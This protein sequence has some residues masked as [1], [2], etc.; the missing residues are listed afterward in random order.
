MQLTELSLEAVLFQGEQQGDFV[1]LR[2]PVD[3]VESASGHQ[4]FRG[5]QHHVTETGV[6]RSLELVNVLGQPGEAAPVQ[7]CDHVQPRQN[8]QVV[9]GLEY[10]HLVIEFIKLDLS[11]PQ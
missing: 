4:I 8:A 10:P 5:C 3:Y 9:A 11:T 7:A 1:A 6:E 2:I